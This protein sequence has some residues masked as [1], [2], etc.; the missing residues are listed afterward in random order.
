MPDSC[1]QANPD[2][3]QFLLSGPDF[4]AL[5]IERSTEP[6]RVIDLDDCSL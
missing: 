5:E 6:A 2:F 4:D 3:K 1:E